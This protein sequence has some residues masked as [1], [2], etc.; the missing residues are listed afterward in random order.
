MY[1]VLGLGTNL[2]EKIKNLQVCIKELNKIFG[3]YHEISKVYRSEP[4]G[5]V[6]QD[7]FLNLVVVYDISD[8]LLAHDLLK[9]VKS[10]E[11]SLG[12][13]FSYHWGPRLIDIDILFLNDLKINTTELTV[14]H[15]QIN[16]RSF[17]VQ[18][19]ESLKIYTYLS[20]FYKFS[21]IFQ[22]KSVEHIDLF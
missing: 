19:L 1:L 13:Q 3:N 4:L 2:G 11:V 18:P 9:T 10:L 20:S 16:E 7:E 14:P 21:S 8:H 6:K 15:T 5:P 12:R 22:T 17:V